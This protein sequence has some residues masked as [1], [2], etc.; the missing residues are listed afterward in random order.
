V[1]ILFGPAQ[2]PGSSVVYELQLFYGLFRKASEE[3]I[4]VIHPAGDE[5]M[6]K[7]L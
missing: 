5:S 2:N 3:A 6:Y 1:F 7:F 4:T